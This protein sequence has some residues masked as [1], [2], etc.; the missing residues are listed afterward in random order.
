M[1]WQTC[2]DAMGDRR[3]QEED[4]HAV[5]QC[6]IMSMREALNSLRRFQ[7]KLS[8]LGHYCTQTSSIQDLQLQFKTQLD[9]LIDASKI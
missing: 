2:L 7:A 5:R 4:N 9:L 1:R 8:Q 6:D 3:L